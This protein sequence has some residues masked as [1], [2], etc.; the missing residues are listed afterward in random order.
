M[1]ELE[2]FCFPNDDVSKL[3][4]MGS[5]GPSG[6][7]RGNSAHTAGTFRNFAEVLRNTAEAYGITFYEVHGRYYY[8]LDNFRSHQSKDFRETSKYPKEDQGKIVTLTIDNGFVPIMDNQPVAEIPRMGAETP[9]QVAEIPLL[10]QGNRGT[11]EQGRGETYPVVVQ[12]EETSKQRNDPTPESSND[13]GPGADARAQPEWVRGTPD[14]PRCPDHDGL[15]PE[16]VPNCRRCARA[17][18]W[19]HDNAQADQAAKAT[20]RKQAIANCNQCDERGMRTTKD[21]HGNTIATRC[22]HQENYF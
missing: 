14:D 2:A 20:A 16:A 18:E 7:S 4:K 1:K 15:K 8:A 19:F 11:E 13:S 22:N 9:A 6:D 21:N 10:E 5:G 17:R 3:P 12:E